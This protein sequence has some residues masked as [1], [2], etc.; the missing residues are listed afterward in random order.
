MQQNFQ[1]LAHRRGSETTVARPSGGATCL[2]T[3]GLIREEPSA[4][5]PRPLQPPHDVDALFRDMDGLVREETDRDAALRNRSRKVLEQARRAVELALQFN[6]AGHPVV[7]ELRH[8][9]LEQAVRDIL[10]GRARLLPAAAPARPEEDP[11]GRIRAAVATAAFPEE[12]FRVLEAMNAKVSNAARVAEAVSRDAALATLLLRLVNSPFYGLGSHVDSLQRAVAFT[13]FNEL[14]A[15]TLALSAVRHF[16]G[17]E[18]DGSAPAGFWRRSI[19]CGVLAKLLARRVGLSGEWFFVAGLLHDTGGL[20]ARRTVPALHALLADSVRRG[21][22][23]CE[24]AEIRLLGRST[25]AIGA[26][27]LRSW[28]MAEVLVRLME[29]RRAPAHVGY[30]PGVCVLH[31][32]EILS[33]AMTAALPETVAVPRLDPK[34]WDTLGLAPREP[35]GLLEQA[36]EDAAGVLGALLS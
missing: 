13:G 36:V 14:S 20:T 8:P 24:A 11:A 12:Y 22:E 1:E 27:L 3:P 4:R 32:A 17:D 15:L 7:S 33:T 16:R 10:A 21:Q 34:A 5:V 35:A 28:G 23:E 18:E 29:W 26:E 25:A 19:I 30:E 2:P 31:L 9:A 6:D